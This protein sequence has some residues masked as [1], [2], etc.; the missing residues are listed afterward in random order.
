MRI[1]LFCT[2]ITILAGCQNQ[3]IPD[4]YT[5]TWQARSLQVMDST[6]HVEVDPIQLTI[7][8]DQRY[9]LSWYGGITETGALSISNNWM[10]I[11]AENGEKRKIRIL[12]FG[13]DTLS[14]S[15]PI[16]D[17]RTEIGFIRITDAEP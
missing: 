12:H 7:Q 15:G 11:T 2:F 14:I 4:E 3:A 16:H 10:N 1:S 6:W 8:H 9:H 5:G 17:Q 13:K